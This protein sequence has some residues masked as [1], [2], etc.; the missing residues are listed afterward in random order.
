VASVQ[1]A[2][3]SVQCAV[4]SVKVQCAIIAGIAELLVCAVCSVRVAGVRGVQCV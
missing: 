1:C 4:C 3:C 2:V